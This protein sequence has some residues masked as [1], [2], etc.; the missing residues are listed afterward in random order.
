MRKQVS[1]IL[2]TVVI[3]CGV[4]Q[5]RLL[6]TKPTCYVVDMANAISAQQEQSLNDILQELEKQTSIRYIVLTVPSSQGEPI[7]QLAARLQNDDWKLGQSNRGNSF[8]CVIALNDRRYSFS[9]GYG[10]TSVLS[11]EVCSR[12][13][14]DILVPHLKA[15]RVS[16]GIYQAN[17]ELIQRLCI[18]KKVR[19]SGMPVLTATPADPPRIGHLA[20]LWGLFP[21]IILLSILPITPLFTSRKGRAASGRRIIIVSII[22]FTEFTLLQTT[23]PVGMGIGILG[24]FIAVGMFLFGLFRYLSGKVSKGQQTGR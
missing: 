2:I 21:I 14:R 4:A 23:G 7:E 19:L 11:E 16:G 22:L 1:I 10:L 6:L 12:I 24:A 9:T 5:A 17:L 18:A 20:L 3:L 15:G 13:G 8:L